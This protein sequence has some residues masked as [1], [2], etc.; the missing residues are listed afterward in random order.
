MSILPLKSEPWRLLH[1]APSS[2]KL[3]VLRHP[4]RQNSSDFV[5]R[6][7]CKVLWWHHLIPKAKIR[8][9]QCMQRCCLASVKGI[10]SCWEPC[11]PLLT[12]SFSKA[13]TC[14][15]LVC[16]FLTCNYRPFLLHSRGIKRP[17]VG[18]NYLFFQCD[19]ALHLQSRITMPAGY[20]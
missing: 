5:A 1:S 7:S 19:V 14:P 16:P 15:R 2:E 11:P 10:T 17:C 3:L 18:I 4:I 20:A 6:S 9:K 12:E 8:C 13:K